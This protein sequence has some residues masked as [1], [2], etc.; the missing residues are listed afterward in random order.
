MDHTN[1]IK[2]FVF[3]ANKANGVKFSTKQ[4]ILD[5][6]EFSFQRQYLP[7]LT[8]KRNYIRKWRC[9]LNS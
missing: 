2:T 7:N 5:I 3:L 4:L 1:N 8:E 9:R 6:N